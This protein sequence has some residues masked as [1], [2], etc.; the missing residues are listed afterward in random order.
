MTHGGKNSMLEATYYGVP[1]VAM[2]LFADQDAQAYR[3]QAQ[4]IGVYVEAAELTQ[5]MLDEAISEI[6]H[7]SM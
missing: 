7:N 3:I 5:G 4:K 1:V 6:L 2:P